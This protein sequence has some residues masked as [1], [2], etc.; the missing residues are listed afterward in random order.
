VLKVPLVTNAVEVPQ[1]ETLA[2]LQII[3]PLPG[4]KTALA[5]AEGPHAMGFPVLP[6]ALIDVAVRVSHPT[7]AMEKPILCLALVLGFILKIYDAETPPLD[8][9]C[10][11]LVPVAHVEAAFP[12]GFGIVVPLQILV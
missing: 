2:V 5:V 4:V 1:L 6:L 8:A 9:R 7:H 3:L 10:R 12:D 11:L